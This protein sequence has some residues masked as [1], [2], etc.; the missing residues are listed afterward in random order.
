MRFLTSDRMRWC[1]RNKRMS[2]EYE[3]GM[4]LYHKSFSRISN[5]SQTKKGRKLDDVVLYRTHLE[6]VNWQEMKSTLAIDG[7]DNGR[8]PQ[9]LETSFRNSYATV[10]AYVDN[11]MVGTARA[12]SDGVS[13]AYIVDVWTLRK[14]RRRGIGC[15]MMGILMNQLQG[16]H[17]ILFADDASSFYETLGFESQPVGMG[18]VVGE[19]LKAKRKKVSG[20]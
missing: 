15:K 16:Q 13:N 3:S 12:L 11:Q 10:I 2:N 19:W 6:D 9:H 14:Y 18:K 8:S 17:V 4:N 20:C 1:I 5:L 7:F